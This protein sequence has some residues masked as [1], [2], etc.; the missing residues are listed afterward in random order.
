MN[1]SERRAVHSHCDQQNYQ[2]EPSG[3]RVYCPGL[4]PQINQK[5]RKRL[6]QKLTN[7]EATEISRREAQ[8]L[9]P[10]RGLADICKRR[11]HSRQSA[12]LH[13]QKRRRAERREQQQNRELPQERSI[14]VRNYIINKESGSNRQQEIERR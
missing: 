5:C 11:L 7:R 4:Q 12:A 1:E 2:R 14:G 3:E 6:L 13:S 8:Q 10:E 9:V